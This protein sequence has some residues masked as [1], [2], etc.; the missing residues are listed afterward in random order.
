MK[1][2]F[3]LKTLAL[4]LIMLL[5]SMQVW[6]QNPI[7]AVIA[8][9]TITSEKGYKYVASEIRQLVDFLNLPGFKR[10]ETNA[11]ALGY[12]INITMNNVDEWGSGSGYGTGVDIG[13]IYTFEIIDEIRYIKNLTIKSASE[14]QYAARLAG[15]FQIQNFQYLKNL[16]LDNPFFGDQITVINCPKLVDFNLNRPQWNAD[17]KDPQKNRRLEIKNCPALK[18]I[19]INC[20]LTEIDMD[21][22]FVLEEVI[23]KQTQI[24]CIDFSKQKKLNKLDLSSNNFSNIILPN[25]ANYDKI[26]RADFTYNPIEPVNLLPLIRAYCGDKLMYDEDYNT[27]E[28]VFNPKKYIYL[29]EFGYHTIVVH[30]PVTGLDSL[31]AGSKIN[32]SALATLKYGTPEVICKG[33]FNW[34]A[35]GE[36][37]NGKWVSLSSWD[38]TEEMKKG[39]YTIPNEYMGAKVTCSYTAPPL[40]N[41]ALTFEIN[42]CRKPG[43]AVNF[44]AKA[45]VNVIPTG[46]E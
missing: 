24:S 40:L 10:G 38:A 28:L 43:K 2:K 42:V 31:P 9:E 8:P 45:S 5:A 26:Y 22:N 13:N 14:Y 16:A 3:T 18:K 30:D 46:C 27:G 25:R 17:Q 21:H 39:I 7:T 37:V 36:N 44:V 12:K 1:E 35:T 4:A 23:I 33:A 11:Q 19:N 15:H 32:L 6:A 29:N 41:D 20:L 34:G